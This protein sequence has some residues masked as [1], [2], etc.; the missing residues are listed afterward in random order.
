MTNRT[1]IRLARKFIDNF[2]RLGAAVPRLMIEVTDRCNL[3]C[4]FCSNKDINR[5]K[6]DIP[7]EIFYKAVNEYIQMGGRV[8]RAY[9]TGEPLMC[10]RFLESISYA[11]GKGLEIRFTSNG[12]LLSEEVGKRILEIGV[13]K[14]NISAE[15]LN[16]NQYEAIRTGGSFDKLCNNLSSFLRM[17]KEMGLNRPLLHIQTVLFDDQVNKAYIDKFKSVWGGLCD[18]ISFSQCGTQGG[19]RIDNCQVI[20]MDDRNTCAYF[21][22]LLCVNNDGTVSVC[23]VDYGRNLVVG[24]I[25]KQSLVEIWNSKKLKEFRKH[26][27]KKN[28]EKISPVC[29]RCTSISR[30]VL[31]KAKEIKSMSTI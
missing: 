28:Y 23:C 17:R 16:R 15:G 25:R 9:S 22:N 20:A 12:Q 24:D 29:S 7:K 8:L 19:N 10:R 27:R 3:A 30:T 1:P 11:H 21:F 14:I 26:V 2:Y 18:S 6:H 5:E 4:S 31:I 13:Q